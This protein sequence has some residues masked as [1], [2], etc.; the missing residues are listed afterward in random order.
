[1]AK[2]YGEIGFSISQETVP[3]VWDEVVTERNYYGD[4]VKNYKTADGNEIIE[5]FNISNQI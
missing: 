5:D 1:M 2:Y 3:G 4:V